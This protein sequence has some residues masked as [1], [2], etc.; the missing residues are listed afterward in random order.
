MT[1]NMSRGMSVKYIVSFYKV[2]KSADTHGAGR[3]HRE[4]AEAL[5]PH[6]NTRIGCGRGEVLRG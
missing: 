1:W 5:S 2:T 6:L 4:V 3:C